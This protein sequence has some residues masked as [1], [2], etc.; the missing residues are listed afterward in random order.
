MSDQMEEFLGAIETPAEE[1]TQTEETTTETGE[2]TQQAAAEEVKTVDDSAAKAK[3]FETA[4]LDE[5]RKR[6][7]L[8]AKLAEKEEKPDFWDDPEARLAEVESR[9]EQ[10]LTAERL[11]ISEAFAREKYPDFQEKLDEFAAICQEQPELFQ[12]MIQQSNPAEYAYKTASTFKRMKEFSSPDEFE[13][14]IRTELEASIRAEYD[15]KL[16]DELKK[17]STLPG[18]LADARATGGN[19]GAT[20]AGPTTLNDIF[21]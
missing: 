16:E 13:A 21:K 1:A 19:A 8:E 20:W 11:N 15:K 9:F 7:E 4:M 10:K 14:K 12:R 5:R 18:S 2:E 17:R 6:Q 3:A